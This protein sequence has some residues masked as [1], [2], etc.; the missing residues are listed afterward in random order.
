MLIVVDLDG[1][2]N[3]AIAEIMQGSR[4]GFYQGTVYSA[5]SKRLI[6]TLKKDPDLDH[7]QK[8]AE[9]NLLEMK[10]ADENVKNKLDQLI[11]GHHA[12]AEADGA[13]DGD[14]VGTATADGPL[15][16]DALGNRTVVTKAGTE[17][18]Q[19]A[20]LPVL[21]TDPSMVAVRIHPD[22]AVQVGVL[23]EPASEWT[24]LQDFSTRLLPE[25][26][27]LALTTERGPDRARLGLRFTEPEDMDADEYPLTTHLVVYAKFKDRP[28][29]RLLKLPVVVVDQ[30]G[31]QAEAQEGTYPAAPNRRT[32]AWRA[33][34]R[35]SSSPTVRRCT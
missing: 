34:S 1:L 20:E 7:L 6:A 15:F 2:K 21:V 25:V 4:Q 12:A 30:K 35:S 33:G 3:E 28:E 14:V 19:A 16:A 24:N 29:A 32:S 22:A 27:G 23:S 26:S 31:A 11:E 13:G 18:G 5:I 17:V 10:A 9:Q 8:D